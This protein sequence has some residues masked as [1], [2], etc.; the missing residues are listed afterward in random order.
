MIRPKNETEDLLLSITGNCQT[1]I[2]QTHRKAEKTLEFKMTKPKETFQFKPPISIEASWMMGLTD[3][4]VYNSIC[5][6]TEENIKFELYK[7]P[8]DTIGGI[9]YIKVKDEIERDLDISDI[10]DTDLQDDLIGPI[11][12]EEYKNK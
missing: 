1:L 8:E 7:F 2:E 9:S 6:I 5:N 4:E 12:I 10:T 3:L 11:F